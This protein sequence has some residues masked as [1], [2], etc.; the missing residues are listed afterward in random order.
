MASPSHAQLE[1]L[2]STSV[3]DDAHAEWILTWSCLGR[4]RLQQHQAQFEFERQN[5]GREV[6]GEVGEETA[7]IMAYIVA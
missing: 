5:A 4:H 1:W 2:R 7:A 3:C 6:D